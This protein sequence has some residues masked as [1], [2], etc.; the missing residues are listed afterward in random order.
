MDQGI[1]LLSVAGLRAEPDHRSEL[2]SQMVFGDLFEVVEKQKDWLQVRMLYDHY[3]GWVSPNQ[4]HLLAES[5]FNDL[6]NSPLTVSTDL[7]QLIE[8]RTHNTSF[9]VGAG[10]SFYFYERGSLSVAG[11]VF[12]YSGS[13]ASAF[14]A[15]P[16]QLAE[17]ALNFLNTPY[18]WGGRSPFGIDCSGFMQLVFKMGGIKIPRDAAVQAS[19][20]ETVHLINEALPGDLLFFDN[21]DQQITHVGLLINEGHIIHAHGKVRID[22]VD[23]NGIFNRDTRRYSHSLRLIKRIKP[24]P[25]NTLK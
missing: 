23:H 12:A 19:Q 16:A 11:K 7:I 6:Q 17:Y 13:V 10:S 1:C 9:A 2:V 18:L 25:T 21:E 3:L 20:G 15:K 8:D 4:L 5:D 24:N 14:P 22:L